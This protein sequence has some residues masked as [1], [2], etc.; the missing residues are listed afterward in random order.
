MVDAIKEKISVNK[1]VDRKKELITIKGDIIVPDSKPDI[2][3]IICTSGTVCVYKKE[4]L[5][6]KIRI[7]GNIDTYIMYL[8][9]SEEDRTRGI[10]TSLDFSEI[11]NISGLDEE[12]KEKTK[13][14]L[15][16]IESNII[17]GR[18]IEISAVLEVDIQIYNNEELEII[19]DLVEE[20]E[21]EMLKET[22][23][24]S[25]IVGKGN[26]SI[27]VKES[28]K[29]NENDTIA[30]ILKTNI[31]IENKDVKVSYNKILTKAEANIKIMYLNEINKIGS[32]NAKVP[33]VG[34]IDI[35]N[36]SDGNICDVDYEIRNIIIKL[37][38][39]DEHSIDLE[40]D[41]GVSAIAYEEKNVNTI[42]DLYSPIR[43]IEYNKK[44]IKTLLNKVN[45]KDERQV[46]E[47]FLID[48][49]D[50]KKVLDVDV[51]PIIESI[52]TFNEKI[53]INGSLEL[54]IIVGDN[55]QVEQKKE[56]IPFN[57]EIENNEDLTDIKTI[58]DIEVLNQDFIVQERGNINSNIDLGIS[59]KGYEDVSFDIMDSIDIKGKREEQDYS[60]VIYV[61]KEGD[62]LWN[63]AKFFGTTVEE[64]LNVNEIENADNL[65]PGEKLFIPR[66]VNY[67]I[68]CKQ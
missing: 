44:K 11:L 10:S 39:N 33:I 32:V 13:V 57:F 27:N 2:L 30:E 58:A 5:N 29:L 42:K 66:Y 46:R 18:K 56:N 34:F 24:I 26:T 6:D 62:T 25:S 16:S 52:K 65:V 23:T 50:N 67:G 54:R 3:N 63:I 53:I 43:I 20:S 41:V 51:N 64:I 15:K 12:S 40:M 21:I 61:I 1:I 19:N 55:N 4:I 47:K 60:V 59:I 36:V 37:N 31:Q 38:S 68:T 48:G 49:L 9:D 14:K 35:E 28:I 7:D 8:A 22:K 17:N 45:I